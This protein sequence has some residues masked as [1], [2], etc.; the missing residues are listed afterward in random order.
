MSNRLA[1]TRRKA[2][3]SQSYRCFYCHTK[4]WE[5]DSAEF[6]SQYKASPYLAK[7]LQSTAEHLKPKCEGGSNT[8]ENIV[9]AC[10]FCNSTRHKAKKPLDSSKYL[11]FVQSRVKNGHWLQVPSILR[12]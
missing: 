9:A 10:Q 12:H 6:I 4:M 11:E 5:S 3:I 2:C 7:K 8:I 1:S